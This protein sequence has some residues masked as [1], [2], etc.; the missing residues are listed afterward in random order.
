MR[1]T[2]HM[3]QPCRRLQVTHATVSMKIL[4]ISASLQI[5]LNSKASYITL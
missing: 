4:G 2:T 3:V 1:L 5:R